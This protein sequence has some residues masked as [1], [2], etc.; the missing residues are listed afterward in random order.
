MSFTTLPRPLDAT[1]LFPQL[2]SKASTATWFPA[3]VAD[4]AVAPL[5][6]KNWMPDVQVPGRHQRDSAAVAMNAKIE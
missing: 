6:S 2:A 4:R 3:R 1:A 5:R